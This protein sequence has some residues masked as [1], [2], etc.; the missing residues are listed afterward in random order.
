MTVKEY[1]QCVEDF[2]D[3]VYRFIL[4]NIKDEEKAKDIVQDTYEKLWVRAE[5]VTYKK[6]K[7]YIFTTAYHTMIDTIRKDSKVTE[8]NEVNNI[9]PS[10]NKQYTGLNEIL[11]Q[12]L[13][14]LPDIQRSVVLLRD[15]E[16]YSYEEIGQITNLSESQVKVYIYRARLALKKFIGSLETVL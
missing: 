14:R 1:N 7:S 10:T 12:A 6:A 9:E 13:N 3:N 15:Y 8:I 5:E 11:E 2:S 4:K 16:G